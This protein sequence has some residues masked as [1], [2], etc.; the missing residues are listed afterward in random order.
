MIMSDSCLGFRMIASVERPLSKPLKFTPGI[1]RI[2]RYNQR[3]NMQKLMKQMQK[4]QSAQG[5]MQEKLEAL[6]LEGSA[7]GGMVKVIS[8]GSGTI[9]SVQI[10]KIVV[11]PSDVEALEDLIVIAIQDAQRK[12]AEAQQSEMQKIMGSM[13]GLPGMR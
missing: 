6:Q 2:S 12:A 13:G 11:D 10:D 3:M 8:N 7:G 4:A 9:Q 1:F 5:E